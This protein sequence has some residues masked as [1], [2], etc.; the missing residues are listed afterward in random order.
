[1]MRTIWPGPTAPAAG[2]VTCASTFPTATAMPSGSPVHSAA[3]AVSDPARVP[4][5]EIGCS[6]LLAKPGELRVE[7]GQELPRRVV[8][9]LPDAL[10]TRGAGVARLGPGELPD[11]PVGGLDPALGAR[12]QLGV[13]L[14]QLQ[15]LGVL[16]F[17]GDLAAVARDPRF[18]PLVGQR[19]D[20]VRV[21]LGR[22][23]FPQLGI[24]VRAALQARERAQR[25][26]VGRGGQHRAGGEV[27][28]DAD[29][30]G[31]VDARVPDGLGDRRPEH[32]QV[33][34]RVLQ[35]PVGRQRLA[36]GGQ[37]AVHHAV[38][39]FVDRGA[40]FRPVADPD[41]ERAPGQGAVVHAHDIPVAVVSA[42][43][44]VCLP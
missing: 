35:G 7:R 41:D 25:R 9:V 37:L 3:A 12:V 4:S 27:G 26:A 36:G 30:R 24:G 19:V 18:L 15:R 31:R 40:G 43:N 21:R 20:P 28:G 10:V 44:H 5:A 8:P 38:P 6:S 16:P 32:G 1:M 17:R 33:V 39:V 23:V 13:L 14:Q 34:G 29:H 22:V 11:D 2:T 42:N